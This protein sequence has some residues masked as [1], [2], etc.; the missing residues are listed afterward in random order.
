M[1]RTNTRKTN[2]RRTNLRRTNI[3]ITIIRRTNIRT[4]IRR[5]NIW[6][7]MQEHSQCHHQQTNPVIIARLLWTF[8]L[9]PLVMFYWRFDY[10]KRFTSGDKVYTAALLSYRASSYAPAL[11]RHSI[12]PHLPSFVFYTVKSSFSLLCIRICNTLNSF[13]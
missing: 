13:V 12:E 8:F 10:F 7:T 4:N 9:L 6:R 5:T 2:I 1:R 3:R 11:F